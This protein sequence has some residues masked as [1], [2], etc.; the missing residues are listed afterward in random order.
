MRIKIF[1]LPIEWFTSFFSIDIIA[2]SV[3]CN[4]RISHIQSNVIILDDFG[5]VRYYRHSKLLLLIGHFIFY[6]SW[7]AN[8]CKSYL[9]QGN[10]SVFTWKSSVYG[11]Q[12]YSYTFCC[13]NLYTFIELKFGYFA[14]LRHY[15]FSIVE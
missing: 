9:K 15:R 1:N 5:Q 11:F 13:T 2:C 6:A 3:Q 14:Y 7:I 12:F 4:T 10:I 8:E